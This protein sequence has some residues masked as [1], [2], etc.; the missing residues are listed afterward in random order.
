MK[1]KLSWASSIHK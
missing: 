1:L